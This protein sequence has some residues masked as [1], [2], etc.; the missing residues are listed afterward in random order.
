MKKTLKIFSALS[1]LAM[2]FAFW[3]IFGYS[4]IEKSM[5][6]IQK[7]FYIH[8]GSAY[9]TFLSVGV[10]ALSSLVVIVKKSAKA[11]SIAL[12]AAEIAMLFCTIVLV[13]GPLWAKP[14]WGTWW[15]WEPRLTTTLI[16]WLML[17]AYFLLRASLP[18]VR[19]RQ[20][21]SAV[22][23]C[24]TALDVPL[25]MFAVKLWRGVHPAIVSTGA[26]QNMPPEMLTTLIVTCLSVMIL[27]FTLGLAR[28]QQLARPQTEVL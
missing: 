4:P 20:T 21:F 15:T 12:C 26:K 3:M 8:V 11:D 10:A 7:I 27:G 6:I 24:F 17:I 22:L 19:Q 25:I 9:V 28:Y 14:V 1:V 13:T 5:G 16:L 2:A 23:M 18:R